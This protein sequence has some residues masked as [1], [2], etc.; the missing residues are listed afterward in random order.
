MDEK[1]N[2]DFGGWIQKGFDIWK[3]NALTL[4]VSGVIV[5]FVGIIAPT[6]VIHLIFRGMLLRHPHIYGILTS[7]IGIIPNVLLA[8][9]LMYAF[10][11]MVLALHDKTEPKPQI[12]D[13][14]QGFAE[15]KTAGLYF[16]ISGV[17]SFVLVIIGQVTC[18]GTLIEFVAMIAFV[19]LTMFGLYFL[20]DK[21]LA[22][23]D[24]YKASIDLVKRSFFPFFGLMIVSGLISIIG[25]I[26]CIVGIF[27]TLPIGMCI[28]ATAYRAATRGETPAPPAPQTPAVPEPPVAPPPAA[29]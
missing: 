19:T 22:V 10:T 17:V 6:A 14:F 15:L 16:L 29:A 5:W 26:G 7:L 2:V 9:P 25:V 24:A 3:G 12:G 23:I 27:A 18:V 28:I 20:V 8:G 13:I 21:Q 4:I 11:K 1:I